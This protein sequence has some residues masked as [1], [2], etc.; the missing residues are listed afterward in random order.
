[1]LGFMEDYATL[2][3]LIGRHIIEPLE[4]MI[5]GQNFIIYD[6]GCATAL[7]HVFFGKFLGYVGVSPP[8]PPVPNFFLPN[9]KFYSG[10]LSDVVWSMDIDYE[11]SFG[12]ANMSILHDPH[13]NTDLK[14]F[15]EVFKRKFIM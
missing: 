1:M 13:C 2:A 7:Q 4:G 8:G 6:I 9:C 5:E 12:I 11:H 15:N 10:H 14:I 3:E